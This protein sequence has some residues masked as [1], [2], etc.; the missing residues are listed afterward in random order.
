MSNHK[1]AGHSAAAPH[2]AIRGAAAAID[3]YV[4]AFGARE[5]FRA[6]APG[7]GLLL[8]A[9]IEIDGSRIMLADEFPGMEGWVAPPPKLN[10]A[11]CTIHIWPPDAKALFDRAVA[12]G[13]EPVM[14]PVEMFWGDLYGRVRDPFGHEWSIA[15][16]LRDVSPEEIARASAEMFAGE[17]AAAPA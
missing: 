16:H 13:A 8:H 4:R 10:G 2:L 9:E 14:P 3:F 7:G 17:S 11:T 15:T 5:A 6:P 12:A 1:P